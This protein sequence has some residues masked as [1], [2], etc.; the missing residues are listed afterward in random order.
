MSCV[1][2]GLNKANDHEKDQEKQFFER[3]IKEI[4]VIHTTKNEAQAVV[5]F[6]K[7]N[8]ASK[9]WKIYEKLKLNGICFKNKEGKDLE[10]KTGYDT[11]E[12]VQENGIPFVAVVFR[13]LP[14][15]SK[16]ALSVIAQK[17]ISRPLEIVWK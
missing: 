16:E 10:F 15:V 11:T 3:I 9:F 12:N 1:P 8:F 14:Y 2:R 13:N 5:R 4:I 6:E 7:D 17:H